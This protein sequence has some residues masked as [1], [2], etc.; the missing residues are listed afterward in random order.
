[1]I[2]PLPIIGVQGLIRLVFVELPCERRRHRLEIC[3]ARIRLFHDHGLAEDGD[4]LT[5]L[6]ASGVH[7]RRALRVLKR[8]AP[9]TVNTLLRPSRTTRGAETNRVIER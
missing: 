1:M 6:L 8:A 5:R 4:E 7:P 2:A 9:H 3:E